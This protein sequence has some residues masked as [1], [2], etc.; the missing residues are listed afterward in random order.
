MRRRQFVGGLVGASGLVA[1]HMAMAQAVGTAP[2]LF[3]GGQAA[4]V[5]RVPPLDPSA[6]PLPNRTKIAGLGH[7]F[8]QRGYRANFSGSTISGTEERARGVLPV[9]AALDG[10]FNLDFFAVFTVENEKIVSVREFGDTA[11]AIDAYRQTPLSG[12]LE[13]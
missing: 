5:P 8:I 13:G 7:S 9:I 11:A 10:R 1:G 4:P 6:L 3:G 2:I 12:K